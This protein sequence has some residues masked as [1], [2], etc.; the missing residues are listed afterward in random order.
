MTGVQTCALPIYER[1][2]YNYNTDLNSD[3]SLK[4]ARQNFGAIT[5]AITSDT[6]FDNANIETLE[7]W[8][9]NPLIQGDVGIVRATGDLNTD[10]ANSDRRNLTGGKLIFNIGDVSEDFVPDGFSNFENGIP[11]V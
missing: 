1:G 3:G 7:F 6:D 8:M 9:M 11:A 2:I 5:R 10:R 4:N